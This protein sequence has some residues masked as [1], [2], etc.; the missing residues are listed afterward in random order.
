MAQSKLISSKEIA[1]GTM[2]FEFEKPEGFEYKSGQSIDLFEIDPPETDAEGNKRAF[3]IASAPHE[4]NLA[5]ATRMRDTAFK[6][7]LKNAQPGLHLEVEGPFGDMV[8]HNDTAK[9]AV[10][11]AGGIGITP[12]HSMIKDAAHRKLAHKIFMFYSNRR[13][14]DAAFLEELQDLQAQN[15]NYKF[16]GTMTEMQNSGKPWSGETGYINKEMLAKYVGDLAAPV[17]YIAGPAAMVKAM[18]EMLNGA[19]INDDLIRTEEFAGY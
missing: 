5:I 16:I 12:F 4:Q 8:L 11:L 18:R 19:G 9:P 15:P 13:P 10:L 6:R 3:S 14:E 2:Q 1:S 17:Y 7:V